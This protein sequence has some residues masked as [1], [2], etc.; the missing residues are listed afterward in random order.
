M[1]CPRCGLVLSAFDTVCTRCHLPASQF[2]AQPAAS[3]P[4]D[5]TGAP[6]P[7]QTFNQP[8]YPPAYPPQGSPDSQWRAQ[9]RQ[10]L[11]YFRPLNT[12]AAV[13]IFF[14]AL[15]GILTLATLKLE[16][17]AMNLVKA[18]NASA[19]PDMASINANDSLRISLAL[20]NLG[21]LI[22]GVIVYLVWIHRAHKNLQALGNRMLEFTPGW[23]AGW[24]FV[25]FLNLVRP[26]QVMREIVGGSDPDTVPRSG[27]EWQAASLSPVIGAWWAAYIIS[28]I[29]GRAATSQ[30]GRAEGPDAFASAMQL[31]MVSDL[32]DLVAIALW[33]AVM[34]IVTRNQ[35]ARYTQSPAVNR[36]VAHESHAKC[37]REMALLPIRSSTSHPHL[38]CALLQAPDTLFK[39]RTTL[40]T[41]DDRI[42]FLA[43][44]AHPRIGVL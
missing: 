40:S 30:A 1:T 31:S 23:A 33:I 25:P 8:G 42:G 34:C 21:V 35:Y 43:A 6:A 22:V 29:L 32:V 12:L 14:A 41:Y 3:G 38:A 7:T 10:G 20:A 15:Q 17:D 26:F 28:G 5:L 16:N 37:G 36:P 44:K 4:T 24:Y 27:T 2:G 9:L 19:I 13:V 18:A 39:A 11:G